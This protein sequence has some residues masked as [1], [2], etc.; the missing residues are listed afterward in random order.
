[1]H[2]HSQGNPPRQAHKGI[3]EGCY[4]EEQGLNGFFGAVSH[5]I[6]KK[7]STRWTKIDGPLKPR[8]FDLVKLG[9]TK[10]GQQRMLFNADVTISM[11][12]LLPVA[13][14]NLQAYRNA[15]GDLLYF[16]HEGSGEIYTEYGMLTYRKGSYI[17]VPKCLMHTIAADVASS[18]FVVE[19]R[20]SHYEQPDRGLLGKHAIYDPAAVL[21]PDLEAQHKKLE[22]LGA[23]LT[24][25]EVK[26]LDQTT[27]FEYSE[28]IYDTISWK[29]DLFPFSLHVDDMMPVMSHRAH[30]PPSAHT[31]FVA[32]E[33]VICTFLPRPLEKDKDAL[34]VPFYH[35][36]I[37][38]DEVL[39]YHEGDFFS[40]DNL[41]AGMMS[42]H[43]AGFPH[44]PHPKAVKAVEQKSETSEYAIM[45]DTRNPLEID[46]KL[47]GV[48]LPDYWKSWRT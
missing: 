42:L 48:E 14:E 38:Y 27:T 5:L 28:N 7:P 3:P 43:P 12:W 22:K 2:Q 40:R 11:Q 17:V 1:M 30:L 20:G 24:K 47:S 39:F 8:M 46:S 23:S 32:R 13:P 6:K 44:G 29:G 16:C 19:N 34:K 31:T 10:S 36:N 9:K 35:Q 18:F 37:D 4:E 45:V 15:D 41:H 33:F 25:V 21:P 26:R